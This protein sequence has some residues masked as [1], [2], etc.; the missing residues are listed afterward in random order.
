MSPSLRMAQAFSW[1]EMAT[2]SPGGGAAQEGPQPS[3][4][5][6]SRKPTAQLWLSPISPNGPA[7][8]FPVRISPQQATSPARSIAQVALRSAA[9]ATKGPPQVLVPLS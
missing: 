8:G 3:I 1:T 7:G 5:R 2:K 4:L 9:I 6:L